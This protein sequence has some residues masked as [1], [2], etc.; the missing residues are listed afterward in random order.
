MAPATF[1]EILIEI[2][3][4]RDMHRHE[5]WQTQVIG[6]RRKPDVSDL[7]LGPFRF[8]TLRSS[9]LIRHRQR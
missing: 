3:P 7:I 2:K 8:E 5:T 4:H 9:D 6:Y 1:I